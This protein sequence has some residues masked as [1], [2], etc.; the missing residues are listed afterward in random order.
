MSIRCFVFFNFTRSIF[1]KLNSSFQNSG[2]LALIIISNHFKLESGEE[3]CETNYPTC[4]PPP[5]PPPPF[6]P[7]KK[8]KKKNKNKTETKKPPKKLTAPGLEP[9][10]SRPESRESITRYFRT[11][12]FFGAIKKK[13]IC[14][15]FLTTLLYFA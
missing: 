13:F 10:T 9:R 11:V 7:R 14:F 6:F 12:F 1:Q 2:S 3:M 8:T 4:P 15:L 5:P